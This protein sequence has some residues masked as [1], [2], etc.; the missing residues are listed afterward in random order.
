MKEIFLVC[1]GSQKCVDRGSRNSVF[2]TS[3][4]HDKQGCSR[5]GARRGAAPAPFF[6]EGQRSAI[7]SDPSFLA[8][9]GSD[10]LYSLCQ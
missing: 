10:E 1:K 6:G 5:M 7:C 3:F 4:I 9:S 2:A 8:Y